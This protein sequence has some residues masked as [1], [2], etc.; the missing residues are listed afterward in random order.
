M[1]NIISSC[2]NPYLKLL[3]SNEYLGLIDYDDLLPSFV[4]LLKL[5]MGQSELAPIYVPVARLGFDV[6]F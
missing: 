6:F 2:F 1:E 3:L 5:V 4:P